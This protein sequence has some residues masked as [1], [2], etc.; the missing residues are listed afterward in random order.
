MSSREEALDEG[1]LT[2]IIHHFY[3]FYY[4]YGFPRC[5]SGKEP[6]YQCKRC[7]FDPW[8]RKWQPSPVF[9]PGQRSLGYSPWNQ[10]ELDMTKH[11]HN[12]HYIS[13]N[14]FFKNCSKTMMNM[15]I[16]A[17]YIEIHFHHLFYSC[18]LLKI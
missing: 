6:T 17:L 9:L 4:H 1:W 8:G 11:M 13:S 2:S 7:W 14:R 5:P 15:A 18:F 3:V 12:Y 16:N 10:E